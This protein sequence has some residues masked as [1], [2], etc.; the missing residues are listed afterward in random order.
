MKRL[1][2]LALAADAIALLTVV[3]G[4]WTRINGA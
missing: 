3:L 1:L 4:S 2:R